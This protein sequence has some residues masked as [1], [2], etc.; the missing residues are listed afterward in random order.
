MLRRPGFPW[1]EDPESSA[2][3]T[4]T[5]CVQERQRS[6]PKQSLLQLPH[7]SENET[8]FSLPTQETWLFS[9]SLPPSE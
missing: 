5:C 1:G 8:L 6:Q 9:Q 3:R 7:L 2:L 4:M